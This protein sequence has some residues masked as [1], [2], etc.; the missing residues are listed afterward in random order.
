MVEN[1]INGQWIVHHETLQGTIS[2][3]WFGAFRI[4]DRAFDW[5]K[6]QHKVVL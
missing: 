5:K 4:E 2:S 6:N 3:R 1:P